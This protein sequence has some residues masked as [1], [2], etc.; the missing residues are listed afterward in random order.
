[1]SKSLR[2]TVVACTTLIYVTCQKR[3]TKKHQNFSEPLRKVV[4]Y[5]NKNTDAE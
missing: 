3:S 2:S 4:W 1:M 5:K